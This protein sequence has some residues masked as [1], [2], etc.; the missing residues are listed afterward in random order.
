M[1]TYIVRTYI[2]VWTLHVNMSISILAKECYCMHGNWSSI[3]VVANS[4]F[5]LPL[6]NPTCF[7]FPI[8]GTKLSE[9]V[10]VV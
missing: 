9:S 1:A 3:A 10:Y 6:L 7:P 8:Y 4:P 2:S 5:V